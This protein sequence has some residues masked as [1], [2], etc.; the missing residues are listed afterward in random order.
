MRITPI[1]AIVPAFLF[2]STSLLAG[3]PLAAGNPMNVYGA[4]ACAAPE[5]GAHS[6]QPG[7]CECQPSCCDDAW[8]GY[9]QQKHHGFCLPCVRPVPRWCSGKH[10]SNCTATCN[11][12]SMAPLK[13]IPE[14]E[15][16]PV[17]APSTLEAAPTPA[18]QLPP[19]PPDPPASQKLK[20]PEE[21][22]KLESSSPSDAT[23]MPFP[24][25]NPAAWRIGTPIK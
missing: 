8:A 18:P 24:V 19:I 16:A 10:A 9:C 11:G 5:Y 1:A 12:S 17:A 25:F 4:G 14:F 23:T 6:L 2:L 3:H 7:C 21:A 13:E 20:K 15:S 22:K